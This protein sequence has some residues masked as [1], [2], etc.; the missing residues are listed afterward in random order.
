MKVEIKGTTSI[1]NLVKAH[2]NIKQI[3][4]SIGF[5]DILKP[6][7]LQSVGRVMTLEKGSRMKNI[8]WA[9]I[10]KT[11]DDNGYTLTKGDAL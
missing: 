2:P 6:G 7:R 11:F 3:M 4:A 1:Y 9:L 10:V 8:D 5:V